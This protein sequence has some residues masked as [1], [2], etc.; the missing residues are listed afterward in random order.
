MVTSVV[1]CKSDTFWLG[2]VSLVTTQR[3][4]LLFGVGD[5]TFLPRAFTPELLLR[6]FLVL[7]TALSFSPESVRILPSWKLFNNEMS[8]MNKY[9][10]IMIV[11]IRYILC[12]NTFYTT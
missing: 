7:W 10:K 11:N 12:A 9:I 8:E 6:S 2:V 5:P 1:G 3:H 4:N